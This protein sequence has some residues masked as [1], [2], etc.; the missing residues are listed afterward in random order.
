MQ[1]ACQGKEAN[2]V[3]VGRPEGK[4]MIGRPKHRC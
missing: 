3:V 4:K 1:H 2:V